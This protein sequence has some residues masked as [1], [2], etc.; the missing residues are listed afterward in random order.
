MR[1]L[2]RILV[3]GANRERHRFFDSYGLMLLHH[4][5]KRFL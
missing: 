5:E 1:R 2:W 3:I 4:G